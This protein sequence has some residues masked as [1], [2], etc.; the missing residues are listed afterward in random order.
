MSRSITQ[1]GPERANRLMFAGAIGLALLAALFVFLALANFGGGDDDGG[2]FSA[3]GGDVDVVVAAQRIEPGTRIT[4]DMLDIATVPGS[5]VI[6]GALADTTGLEG[7]VAR[8]PIERGEQITASKVGGDSGDDGAAA[9]V[10]PGYRAMAVEVQESTSVGGLIVPG[11][12]VDVV[13]VIEEGDTGIKRG[14]TLLQNVEVLAVAQ[15]ALKPVTRLDRDGNPIQTDT[16]DGVL[17]ERPDDTE[18]NEDARTV[19]LAILP[20]DAPLLALAQED[21]TIFLALR[22]PG[23]D[24]E[25]PGIERFIGDSFGGSGAA[26]EPSTGE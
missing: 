2:G 23:D 5:T 13:A 4:A 17:A 18:A 24:E 10:P 11:D 21:G 26:S 16:A 7:L 20:E 12:R 22:G 25:V 3:P 6:E 8:V 1:A 19:T 9:V 15:T 14:V